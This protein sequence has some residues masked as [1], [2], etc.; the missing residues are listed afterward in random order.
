MISIGTE[1]FFRK[2][3]TTF[4]LTHH[5]SLRTTLLAREE[6]LRE[7]NERAWAAETEIRKRCT[8]TDTAELLKGGRQAKLAALREERWRRE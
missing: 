2:V 3:Q 5:Q 7:A 1:V 8:A 4:L 6:K